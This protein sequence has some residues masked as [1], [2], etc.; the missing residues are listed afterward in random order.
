VHA[1]A[2]ISHG[3]RAFSWAGALLFAGALGWFLFSYAVRFG[4][5][6]PGPL[7]AGDVAWDVALFSAFALHH[8]IFARERVRALVATIIPAGLERSLYV[9]IASVLLIVVCALW[10][11]VGGV[12][13]RVEGGVH[14]AL[15]AVQLAG[16]WLTLRSAAIID[17]LD[18]AGVRKA[19]ALRRPV[20]SVAGGLQA[21]AIEFKTEGPYGWVRHPIYSGW[22][23]IVFGM[24][25]MT[26]TQ[27]VFALVSCVYVLI[28]IPFEERSLRATT[29]GAYA[30]YSGKVKHKLVPGIY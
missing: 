2:A 10:R 7:R 8:S 20:A 3:A 16:I 15:I 18:L 25:T 27:L 5:A 11:P 6:A 24:G 30:T 23:L 4:I 12:A 13:W 19:D 14:G 26:M 21:S 22:F 1:N 9:W 17:V 29:G 28:A